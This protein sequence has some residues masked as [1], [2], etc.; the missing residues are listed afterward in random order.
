[1]IEKLI[2]EYKDLDKIAVK[3]LKKGLMFCFVLCILSVFILLIYE[4]FYKSPNTYYIGIGIF[5]LS[6][7][8]AVDFIICAKS[9][10]A[11]KKETL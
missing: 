3:I 1:M 11:I 4:V 9:V 5:K 6:L 8:F 2:N 10:D 7:T